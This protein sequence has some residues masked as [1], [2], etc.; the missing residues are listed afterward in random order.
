MTS[1]GDAKI[2]EG[3]VQMGTGMAMSRVGQRPAM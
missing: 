1:A 3:R 2:G